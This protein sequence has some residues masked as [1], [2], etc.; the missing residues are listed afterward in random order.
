[1]AQ[2]FSYTVENQ[3]SLDGGVAYLEVGEGGWAPFP[4]GEFWI[5]DTERGL[6]MVTAEGVIDGGLLA[7]AKAYVPQVLETI[8]FIDLDAS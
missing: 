1:M 5:F 3:D 2:G 7:E 6:F 8:E 4:F